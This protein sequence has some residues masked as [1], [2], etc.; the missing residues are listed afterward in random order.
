MGQFFIKPLK[1]NKDK[2]WVDSQC[3]LRNFIP[4]HNQSEGLS[5]I[6]STKSGNENMKNIEGKKSNE[7]YVVTAL[8][9]HFKGF[10]EV[11]ESIQSRID[12]I[13]AEYP[14][15]G[16]V[17]NKVNEWAS[18][19]EKCNDQAKKHKKVSI[20]STM[21]ETPSRFLNLSQNEDTENQIISSPLIVKRN[22]EATQHNED[23]IIVVQ[24]SNPEKIIEKETTS[25][26]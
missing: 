14:N 1:G 17:H 3:R 9:Y 25:S 18:L 4:S 16:I 26:L 19:I 10:E 15:S 13:I 2:L 21:I 23:N 20:D 22:E 6:H 11:F 5:D 12:E 24:S 8:D 7:E